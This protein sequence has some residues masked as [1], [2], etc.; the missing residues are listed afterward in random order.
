MIGNFFN[1]AQSFKDMMQNMFDF[2]KTFNFSGMMPESNINKFWELNKNNLG[3]VS[4]LQKS[5]HDDM[6]T[7]ADKQSALVK[8]NAESLTNAMYEMSRGQMT[9]QRLMEIRDRFLQ[10]STAKTIDCTKKI[11][12]LCSKT[13]MKFFEAYSDQVKKNINETCG[14]GMG[15]GPAESCGKP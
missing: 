15:S 13:S 3:S 8:E 7:I 10:E 12:E 5:L 4:G 6:V 14:P 2:G 1:P 11:A 9:P